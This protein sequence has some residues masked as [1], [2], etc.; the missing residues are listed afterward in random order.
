[1]AGPGAAERAG[2]TVEP[3]KPIVDTSPAAHIAAIVSAR[4]RR[5]VSQPK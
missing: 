2:A 4:M 5:G 1:V 3:L